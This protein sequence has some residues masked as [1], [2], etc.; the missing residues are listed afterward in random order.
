VVAVATAVGAPLDR[1]VEG[2][3]EF[4]GA[5][6]RLELKGEAAGTQVF[7]SYAHH[8]TELT[9]DLSATRDYVRESGRRRLIAVFQPHLYSRT[10]FFATEFGAALGGADLAIVL[11]V[12]GA[13]EDPEPGVTGRLISDAVPATTE[14]LYQPD[15]GAAAGQIAELA[16]PGDVIITAGA[17]DITTL[18]PAI[19]ELLQART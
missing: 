17:G 5:K 13:R 15:F 3:A 18:G 1:V 19:L 2:L 14:V 4:G 7:D 11:D 10:R 12:Y 9:A 16:R 6:R 8:P